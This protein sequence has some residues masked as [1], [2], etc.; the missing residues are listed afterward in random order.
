MRNSKPAYHCDLRRDAVT[1]AA[2]QAE[3]GG[4]AP[5]HANPTRARRD[6]RRRPRGRPEA[7]AGGRDPGGDAALEQA[8]PVSPRRRY[9][10]AGADESLWLAR[11]SAD[12]IGI[13][14]DDFCRQWTRS[15]QRG[16]WAAEA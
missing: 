5:L 6:P 2:N 9:H 3:R 1:S 4:D 13:A 7:R 10:A 15:W 11:A 14:P 8:N 12:I 16:R